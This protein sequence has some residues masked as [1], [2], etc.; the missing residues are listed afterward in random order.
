MVRVRAVEAFGRLRD[1][2]G[3]EHVRPLLADPDP[4]VRSAA[5]NVLWVLEHLGLTLT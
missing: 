1:K 2:A 5:R 4:R 3:V